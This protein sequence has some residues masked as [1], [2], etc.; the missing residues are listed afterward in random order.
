MSVEKREVLVGGIQCLCIGL[1][2]FEL[3]LNSFKEVKE[4]K[5][6]SFVYLIHGVSILD[7]FV[8]IV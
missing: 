6:C 7:I 4:S 2:R 8:I 1:K 5:E 3:L